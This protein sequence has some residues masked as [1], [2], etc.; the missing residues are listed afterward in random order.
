VPAQ[1]LERETRWEEY[2]REIL[3]TLI[4]SGLKD[5]PILAIATAGMIINNQ[6]N[7]QNAESK[8]IY[9]ESMTILFIYLEEQMLSL[10]AMSARYSGTPI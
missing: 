5:M 10:S 1:R 9:C 7:L 4:F 8:N 6:R 3:T 2:Y